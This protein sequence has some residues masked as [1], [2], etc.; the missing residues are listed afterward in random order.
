MASTRTPRRIAIFTNADPVWALHAWARTIPELNRE[1]DVV[2]I[3]LFPSRLKRMEGSEIPLWYLR[4]FGIRDFFLLGAFAARRRF[5]LL[6]KPYA[7]WKKLAKAYD[8]ELHTG[9]TPNDTD[10]V[11]WVRDNRIDVIFITVGHIL[12]GEILDTPAVGIINKHA[13]VLPHCRGL[14]PYFWTKLTD[15]PAG[16]TFHRV[17]KGIDTG[18]ILV[19]AKHMRQDPL[20]SMLRFYIDVFAA[21]PRMAKIAMDRI[22]AESYSKSSPTESSADTATYYS[23]PTTADVAAYRGRSFSTTSFTDLFYS[24]SG[25][26]FEFTGELELFTESALEPWG[27]RRTARRLDRIARPNEGQDVVTAAESHDAPVTREL[28]QERA[29]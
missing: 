4:T 28:P 15:A 24:P 9:N 13:A 26:C 10:V 25:K 16:V 21:F 3:Y 19:Q 12:K 2:G 14:F 18:E 1:D 6:G 20:M 29:G 11:H 22:V 23:A 17:E 5:E 7:N 27:E 8:I